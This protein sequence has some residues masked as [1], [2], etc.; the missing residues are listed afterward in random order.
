[1]S[2]TWRTQRG[3]QKREDRP[4][5][6]VRGILHA[7][8]TPRVNKSHPHSAALAQLKIDF[9]NRVT[10]QN[11]FERMRVAHGIANAGDALQY[12]LATANLKCPPQAVQ[13]LNTAQEQGVS[14]TM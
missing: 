7:L 11:A 1:M 14:P 6:L 4:P 13:L 9:R 3:P 12:M 10:I 8:I 2:S 5:R